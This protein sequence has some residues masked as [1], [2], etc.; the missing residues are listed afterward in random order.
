M[1]VNWEAEGPEYA[2]C[3]CDY[4]CPCQSNAL[5]TDGTCNAFAMMRTDMRNYFLLALT[6][7]AS[8][9]RS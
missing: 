9:A 7:A 8:V 2:K 5:P 6:S 3:N 1:G 4:G